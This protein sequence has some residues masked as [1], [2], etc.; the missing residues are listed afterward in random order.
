MILNNLEKAQLSFPSLD[1][2]KVKLPYLAH[3]VNIFISQPTCAYLT[4]G[5]VQKFIVHLIILCFV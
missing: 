1:Q 2:V 5:F 4:I 3:Q